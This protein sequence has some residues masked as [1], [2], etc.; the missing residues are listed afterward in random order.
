MMIRAGVP[1]RSCNVATLTLLHKVKNEENFNAARVRIGI[2]FVLSA[3]D[4]GAVGRPLFSS[5]RIHQFH[6]WPHGRAIVLR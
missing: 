4:H 5:F 3:V 6:N 2:T 1:C